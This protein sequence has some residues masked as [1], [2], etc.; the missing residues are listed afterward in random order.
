MPKNKNEDSRDIAGRASDL[1]TNLGKGLRNLF[2]GIPK[3]KVAKKV[4]K[5]PLKK[6]SFRN[7]R[8]KAVPVVKKK[9][10]KKAPEKK[11][12]ILTPAQELVE[13]NSKAPPRASKKRIS[14]AKKATIAAATA[15]YSKSAG[16]PDEIAKYYGLEDGVKLTRAPAEPKPP[17][18]DKAKKIGR[19]KASKEEL[20]AV[21]IY[22]EIESMG[23]KTPPL[24]PGAYNL[25]SPYQAAM[26]AYYAGRKDVDLVGYVNQV[27]SDKKMSL[28]Y[29]VYSYIKKEEK[30]VEKK[31]KSEEVGEKDAELKEQRRIKRKRSKKFRTQRRERHSRKNISRN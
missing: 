5:R 21:N 31:K 24:N 12:K 14:R 26:Y 4:A 27:K 30:D 2:G 8:P 10:A 22:K 20:V 17:V 16:R 6:D 25:R 29:K 13:K 19:P 7:T 11:K 28:L 9:V 18:A 1:F 23:Y 15:L 3:K